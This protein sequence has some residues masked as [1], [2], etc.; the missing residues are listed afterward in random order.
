MCCTTVCHVFG[1]IISVLD[2]WCFSCVYYFVGFFQIIYILILIRSARCLC[3]DWCKYHFTEVYLFF[4]SLLFFNSFIVLLAHSAL[5]LFCSLSPYPKM[6]MICEF[7]I[8][9]YA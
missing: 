4:G 9:V 2:V 7:I 3:M 6:M 1:T 8:K 5:R